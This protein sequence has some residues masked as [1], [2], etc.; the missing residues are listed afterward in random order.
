MI[1]TF[2]FRNEKSKIHREDQRF[3]I[4][5][6]RFSISK[7]VEP[8]CSSPTDRED[9]IIPYVFRFAEP[10]DV[11]LFLSLKEARDV[12]VHELRG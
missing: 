3:V 9:I 10:K 4:F 1:N 7:S 5:D 12:L 2:I 6:L 11:L 8:V